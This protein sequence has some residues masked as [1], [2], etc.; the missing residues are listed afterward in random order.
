[1]AIWIDGIYRIDAENLQ[2]I[3]IRFTGLFLNYYLLHYND[4]ELYSLI[5]LQHV[6]MV[7][8]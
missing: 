5:I 4:H 1:M 6:S 8:G 7:I 3:I 2:Q